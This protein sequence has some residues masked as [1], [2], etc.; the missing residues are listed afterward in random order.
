MPVC[1]KNF[2]Y[3]V[4]L[5]QSRRYSFP[6]LITKG[7]DAFFEEGMLCVETMAHPNFSIV[8]VF[9]GFPSEQEVECVNDGNGSE[10]QYDCV[11]PTLCSDHRQSNPNGNQSDR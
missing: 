1:A 10:R 2:F 11:K 6:Y 9:E 5:S 3:K 8:A 7:T 4:S